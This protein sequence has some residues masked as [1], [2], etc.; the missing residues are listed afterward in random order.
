[1]NKKILKQ[2]AASRKEALRD[3]WGYHKELIQDSNRQLKKSELMHFLYDIE[4]TDWEDVGF[5]IGYLRALDD[6]EELIEK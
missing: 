6:I 2:I 5:F 3:C 1:M 4:L